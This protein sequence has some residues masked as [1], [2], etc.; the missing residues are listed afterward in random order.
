MPVSMTLKSWVPAFAGTTGMEL[1]S[2][3]L[4]SSLR[5]QRGNLATVTADLPF[6]R[7]ARISG[8]DETIE[9]TS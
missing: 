5:A 9:R 8:N 6:H 3:S 1:I 7:H 4:D 2:D